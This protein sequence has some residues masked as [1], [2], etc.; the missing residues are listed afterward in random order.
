MVKALYAAA[1]RIDWEHLPPNRRT[2]QYD[3]WVTDVAI[4]GVLTKYM[5]SENARSWIKDGPMKEYGRARL[6]A[7][8]YARFG[9]SVG[10]TAEQLV[11]HALGASAAVVENSQGVK[12]FHCLATVERS[13]AYVVWDAAKNLR[14]LV[15]A[16]IN[17]LA[18]NPE[19]EGCIVILETLDHPITRADKEHHERIAER[20]SLAIKYYR[21]ISRQPKGGE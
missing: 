4:G 8:R 15:W 2:A 19:H 1:D 11:S 7:G 9:T 21:V 13:T 12:P 14:H 5:S 3:E 10:P 6:G 17:H 18:S 16:T 20:C